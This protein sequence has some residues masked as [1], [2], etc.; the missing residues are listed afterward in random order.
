[1][2]GVCSSNCVSFF[3]ILSLFYS[4]L[5]FLPKTSQTKGS[6]NLKYNKLKM[7]MKKEWNKIKKIFDKSNKK[8]S[9]FLFLLVLRVYSHEDI[10]LAFREVIGFKPPQGSSNV[11][12]LS[13]RHLHYFIVSIRCY[14]KVGKL[15][16]T[17]EPNVYIFLFVVVFV[18]QWSEERISPIKNVLNKTIQN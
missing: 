9:S 4:C 7:R 8:N 2:I 5:F 11:R 3:I 10:F 15:W 1:M 13:V 18:N 14:L 17:C 12:T 16:T 6:N